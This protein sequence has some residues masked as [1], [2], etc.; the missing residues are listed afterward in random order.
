M[1]NYL[2]LTKNNLVL[3]LVLCSHWLSFLLICLDVEILYGVAERRG[4]LFVYQP[5]SKHV[6][7]LGYH[8]ETFLNNS[9]QH[10]LSLSLSFFRETRAA[11][12]NGL[13]TPSPACPFTAEISQEACKHNDSQLLSLFADRDL[14]ESAAGCP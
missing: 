13:V 14:Q 7:V 12:E 4:C 11:Q 10:L 2:G 1:T 5:V 6:N 9:V 3:L 8:R